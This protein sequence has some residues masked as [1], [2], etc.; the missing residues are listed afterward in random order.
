MK[1]PELGNLCTS[2]TVNLNGV[3]EVKNL[4]RRI[5]K[6]EDGGILRYA[7]NDKM[8]PVQRFPRGRGGC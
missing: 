8:S 2:R 5:M 4:E 7:Q 3:C 6:T 1:A